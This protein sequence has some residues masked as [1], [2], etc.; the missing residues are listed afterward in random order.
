MTSTAVTGASGKTGRAI[1]AALRG[2]GERVV[3]VGRAEWLDLAASLAS[4]DRLYVIAPNMHPDEPGLVTEAVRA[5]RAA[6]VDRIV[7]HSVA[8]PYVPALPH[9]LAKA[10]AED[11]VRRSGLSW[12]ILQPCAYLQNFLPMISPEVGTIEV[13]YDVQQP[14]GLVDLLDVAEAAAG[15][16]LD[17][18]HGGATYELGGPALV[19]VADVA[20]AASAQLGR[21]IEAARV[22]PADWAARNPQPDATT[23]DSLLAMFSYYDA[24]GLPAGPLPLRALLGRGPHSLRDVLSRELGSAGRRPG[25]AAG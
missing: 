10:Q 5:A 12:T 22:D 3:E 24:H 18:A 2:Q 4:A 13:P 25:P 6:G 9:H 23:R 17:D 19:S 7:Y 14:F 15:V 21:R 8:S 11:I 20:R 1:G 16:L